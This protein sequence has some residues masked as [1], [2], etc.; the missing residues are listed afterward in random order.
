M[1]G[2]IAGVAFIVSFIVLIIG[3]CQN[4]DCVVQTCFGVCIGCILA[5]IQSCIN[6]IIASICAS[7]FEACGCDDCVCDPLECIDIDDD[8]YRAS[9]GGGGASGGF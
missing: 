6:A 1:F 7:I 8:G 5:A 4:W 2:V 3:F 9:D